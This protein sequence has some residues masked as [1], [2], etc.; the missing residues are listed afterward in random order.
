[1]KACGASE[2]EEKPDGF[3]ITQPGLLEGEKLSV[4]LVGHSILDD[5]R[6]LTVT[7]ESLSENFQLQQLSTCWLTVRGLNWA[8][9][10][11]DIVPQLMALL[12]D[13]VYFQVADND[14]DSLES[15]QSVVAKYISHANVCVDSLTAKRVIISAA[16]PRRSTRNI[17]PECY[18]SKV[19]LFNNQLKGALCHSVRSHGPLALDTF[20]DPRVWFWDHPRLGSKTQFKRD[21]VH[22]ADPSAKRLFFSIRTALREATRLDWL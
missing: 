17:S 1:L 21:G 10:R 5:L 19:V 22:L 16:L 7:S 8:K 12:P 14:L 3:R 9:M 11:R 2:S 20:K 15:V 18:N 6:N 4:A 13:V